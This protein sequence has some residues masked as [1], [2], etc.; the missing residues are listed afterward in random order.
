M[1]ASE[2]RIVE[3]FTELAP[4]YEET[5]DRELRQYLSIGY[6]EVVDELLTQA[7]VR[8]D[9]WVLDVATGTA[10]IPRRLATHRGERGRVVGLDITPAMLR[11]ARASLNRGNPSASTLLTAASGMEI[12]FAPGVFDVVICAF[13]AHHMQVPR[14]LEEIRRVL[15]TG[16][17]AVLAEAGAP[18]L[19]RTIVG[20]VMLKALMLTLGLTKSSARAELEEEAFT[21]IYTAQEWRTMLTDAGFGEIEVRTLRA[22]RSWYPRALAMR[23]MVE[24]GRV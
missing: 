10:L 23:A 19:W 6:C 22:R 11:G 14:M 18:P 15:R 1:M 24:N 8:P 13:G 12:P 21:T 20:R 4:Q 17:R 16:G 9:D 7:A 5:M 3:V 2:Q